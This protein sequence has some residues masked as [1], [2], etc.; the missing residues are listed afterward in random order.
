MASTIPLEDTTTYYVVV[1][2]EFGCKGEDSMRVFI[3]REDRFL[4]M[5]LI[6]PNGDGRNDELDLGSITNGDQ[7]GI[8]ILNR[9][10]KEVYRQAIYDNQWG[11]FSTAGQP[12]ED[13]TYYF[14]LKCGN[15]IRF[16]G[17]VTIMRDAS[18]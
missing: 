1:T 8:S 11:G 7:C 14:I 2:D 6:T 10:G 12:L 18:N 17:P 4:I 5:N 3:E 13:G 9:W 15:S 16:K